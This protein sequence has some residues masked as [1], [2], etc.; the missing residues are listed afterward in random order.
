[1]GK[2]IDLTGQRFGKLVVIERVEKDNYGRW[3]C[4]CD[5][6]NTTIARSERL[7]NGKKQSCGCLRNI[8]KNRDFGESNFDA[9]YGSYKHSA[10]TRNI[11]F[12]LSKEEFRKI[13]SSNC[14]YCGK[15]PSQT[16]NQTGNFRGYYL[17]NGIDRIDSQGIYEENNCVPCCKYCNFAKRNMTKNDFLTHIEKIYLYKIKND[18]E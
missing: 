7:K 14:F 6:G 3:L 15:E 17:Y 16:K 10:K 8:P 18:A 4:K 1:L 13:T 2:F 11:E 12:N 9:L 5:C